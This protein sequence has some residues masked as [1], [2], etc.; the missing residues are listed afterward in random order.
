MVVT[1]RPHDG[2]QHHV[3]CMFFPLLGT[4]LAHA[5]NVKRVAFEH[6][7]LPSLQHFVVST[8]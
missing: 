7:L 8:L 6:S 3:A 4:G 1:S 2:E 5:D